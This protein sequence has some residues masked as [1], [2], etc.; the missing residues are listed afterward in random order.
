MVCG[1]SDVECEPFV[2]NRS[3]LDKSQKPRIVRNQVKH[4]TAYSCPVT[5]RGTDDHGISFDLDDHEHYDKYHDDHGI[6]IELWRCLQ[7]C[8]TNPSLGISCFHPRVH[9]NKAAQIPKKTFKSK[10][11][12]FCFAQVSDFPQV[13]QSSLSEM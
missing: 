12:Q 9:N 2:L 7:E 8:K 1:I 11:Q 6:S 3:P 4:S 13:K 5:S 10:F